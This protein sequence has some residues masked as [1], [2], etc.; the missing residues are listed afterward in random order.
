MLHSRNIGGIFVSRIS[1]ICV[2][3]HPTTARLISPLKHIKEFFRKFVFT[4]TQAG[5]PD[6]THM[7]ESLAGLAALL[8][9]VVAFFRAPRL[10]QLK[11]EMGNCADAYFAPSGIVG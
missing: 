2:P 11:H 8:A 6:V 4:T 10:E 7:A 9:E 3:I 1:R 5:S